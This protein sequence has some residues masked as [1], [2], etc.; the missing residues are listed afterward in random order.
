MQG[1]GSHR[2]EAAL[3]DIE[4]PKEKAPLLQTWPSYGKAV[5]G[6]LLSTHSFNEVI[7]EGDLLF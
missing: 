4:G 6:Q 3:P 2:K 7:N 5:P 1:Q